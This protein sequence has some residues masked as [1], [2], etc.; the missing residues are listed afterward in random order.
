MGKSWQRRE[1]ERL[2][3]RKKIGAIWEE[4]HF[5]RTMTIIRNWTEKCKRR[6]VVTI[7]FPALPGRTP[8][9]IGGG[10]GWLKYKLWKRI[11]VLQRA[12]LRH[13]FFVKNRGKPGHDFCKKKER[14][15]K[16]PRCGRVRK[17]SPWIYKSSFF[18]SPC[19]NSFL[20]LRGKRLRKPLRFSHYQNSFLT[21]F[22]NV[23][24]ETMVLGNL[25]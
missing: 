1:G 24:D 25:S 20:S 17:D 19:V 15:R 6:A 22:Q 4:T 9:K 21:T 5:C 10:R 8:A 7:L 23:Q 14:V 13:S 11:D 3:G 12:F 16:M 18:S 2:C